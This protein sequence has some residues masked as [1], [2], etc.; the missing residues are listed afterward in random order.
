M[1]NREVTTVRATRLDEVGAVTAGA[2]RFAGAIAM[3]FVDYAAEPFTAPE[4]TRRAQVP[5]SY[6][7][8]VADLTA[9]CF[10]FR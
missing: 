6:Y 8:R 3:M 7:R 1:K 4:Q 10:V 9:L 5:A 2:A